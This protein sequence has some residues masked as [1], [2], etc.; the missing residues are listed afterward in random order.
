MSEI[1][2]RTALIL[3]REIISSNKIKT[4]CVQKSDTSKAVSVGYRNKIQSTKKTGGAVCE[5]T[6]K[7]GFEWECREAILG[8]TPNIAEDLLR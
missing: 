3:I 1:C 4:Q 6:R 5:E 7:H 2:R 8:S